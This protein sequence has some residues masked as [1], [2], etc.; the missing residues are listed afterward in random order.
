MKPAAEKLMLELTQRIWAQDGTELEDDRWLVLHGT[1][2]G[3]GGLSYDHAEERYPGD[4]RVSQL[5]GEPVRVRVS[6]TALGELAQEGLLLV[7]GV[8]VS[9]WKGSP[10]CPRTDEYKYPGWEWGENYFLGPRVGEPGH[11]EWRAV[12]RARM[13]WDVGHRAQ[14]GRTGQYT[15]VAVSGA[16]HRWLHGHTP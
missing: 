16:G 1:M 12:T 14:H 9:P 10:P 5:R 4:Y 13:D 15:R 2:T 3:G 7:Q 6:A 11:E 8:S